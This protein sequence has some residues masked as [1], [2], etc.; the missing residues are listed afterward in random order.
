MAIHQSL[1]L[2]PT[3]AILRY[4]SESK[5]HAIDVLMAS[6]GE[7]MA[8]AQGAVIVLDELISKFTQARRTADVM[9]EAERRRGR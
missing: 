5:N 4:L 6:R 1:A 9:G 3:G 7:D 8:R 2:E